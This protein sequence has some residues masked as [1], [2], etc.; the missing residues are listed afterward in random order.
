MMDVLLALSLALSGC[1][2]Q[3]DRHYNS[4]T[5]LYEQG[6]LEGAIRLDPQFVEAYNNRGFAYFDLGDYHLDHFTGLEREL[7]DPLNLHPEID[8]SVRMLPSISRG[9]ANA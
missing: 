1:S 7:E 4:G 2:T 3:A 8:N 5:G 9:L 6:R